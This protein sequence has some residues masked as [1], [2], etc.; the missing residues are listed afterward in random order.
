MSKQVNLSELIVEN[1]DRVDIRY[2]NMLIAMTTI[3]LAYK[4]NNISLDVAAMLMTI[5]PNLVG[6]DVE[7]AIDDSK[8]FMELYNENRV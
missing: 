3:L 5:I 7:K 6:E 4:A 1:F 2:Q 8:R